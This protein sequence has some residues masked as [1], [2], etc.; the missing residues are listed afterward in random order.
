MER[1][2]MRKFESSIIREIKA[3]FESTF[4]ETLDSGLPLAREPFFNFLESRS[5]VELWHNLA[6]EIREEFF[7]IDD[8]VCL[9]IAPT[10][11]IFLP[12]QHGTSF[13]TDYLYGHGLG[14]K[15]VWVP[16]H[17]VTKQNS[18][19]FLK[20][21]RE[22]EFAELNLFADYTVELEN[23]LLKESENVDVSDEECVVFSSTEI[24]GSPIN[25]SGVARYSFDFRMSVSVDESSNKNLNQYFLLS[26]DTWK[27]PFEDLKNR[28]FLKY[29]CGS[30]RFST[31]A[32][33]ILINSISDVF[34]LNI[35]AQEAELER[36]GHPIF[37]KYLDGLIEFKEFDSLIVASMEILNSEKLESY[38]RSGVDIFVA[39]EEQ[40]LKE[41]V[42]CKR[43]RQLR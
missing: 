19:A 20:P 24:H 23:K 12:N 14:S 2:N 42:R 34:Q 36:F 33:H 13:H 27:N 22:E 32:Q 17:G 37:E 15:T 25:S 16:L 39:C 41:L 5:F 1:T 11:R 21:G 38:A 35:V 26:D 8:D 10:P 7:E 3:E 9:Q 18:F 43:R 31:R 28:K 40:F 6:L 4:S 29:I 30:K